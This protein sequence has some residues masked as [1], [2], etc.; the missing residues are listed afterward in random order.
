MIT[1]KTKKYIF[2]SVAFISIVLFIFWL[3]YNPV[4]HFNASIPG[5][6]HRPEHKPDTVTTVNIGEKFIFIKDHTSSLKGK[7][8]NF[9]GAD[10]DNINKEEIALIDQFGKDGPDIVWRLGLGEGHASAAIYNGKVYI[11]DYN[12]AKKTDVLKCLILETGEELWRR[13]YKVNIKRNHGIS[14]TIP[15]VNDLYVVTIGPKGHVMCVSS[16]KG[17][18]LWGIDLEKAYGT[19]IPYW[20]TGQC[21][22][23]DNNVAVIAPGGKS[24]MIGVDCRTGKVIWET[25]NK[26]KWKMS[27]S[28]VMPMTYAGKKMYVYAAIGGICGVEAEGKNAGEI[29]WESK[30]V[31]ANVI[32]PSP[33]VLDD[34]NIFVT[35]GYGFGA[36]ILKLIPDGDH[37]SAEIRQ[38]YGPTEGIC[39]EQQTP[40][41][42][43]GSIFAI[44]PKDAG[45]NRNQFVCCEP[46]DGKIFRWTSG[47]ATRFGLGPY[48]FA[49]NKFYILDDEGNLT[50]AEADRSKFKALSRTK[51]LDGQDAWG[52]LALADGF[53]IMRDSKEMLCINIRTQNDIKK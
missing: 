27:H 51:I 21:P 3:A 33:L 47:K 10:F 4:K 35:A 48:L 32:A 44:L 43:K 41:F 7:W 45:S 11:L 1:D 37:F 22:L 39:S 9:R 16:D 6:D 15:A 52:P 13:S 42:Y 38:K 8:P 28:S 12:E 49:D 53:L 19:E 30:A 24:L 25:P 40:L 34:G 36:V 20:N 23:I 31:D 18:F 26:G 17:D 14:R 29:L 50:I 46:K 2:L 5:L